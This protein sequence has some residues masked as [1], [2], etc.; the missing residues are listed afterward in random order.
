L[1]AAPTPVLLLLLLLHVRGVV[2]NRKTLGSD[3]TQNKFHICIAPPLQRL[4]LFL[5]PCKG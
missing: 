5:K 2:L 1:P 3:P 4:N